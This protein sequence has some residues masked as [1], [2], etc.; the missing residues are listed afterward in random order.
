MGF[1]CGGAANAGKGLWKEGD[2]PQINGCKTP[3]RMLVCM[4][5]W[6]TARYYLLLLL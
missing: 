3:A 4:V 5:R 6:E 2:Y 1:A